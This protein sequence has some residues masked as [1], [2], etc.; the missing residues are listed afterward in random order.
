MDALFSFKHRAAL[1]EYSEY[2]K[3]ATAVVGVM[4]TKALTGCN[5]LAGLD[6]QDGGVPSEH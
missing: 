4:K 5:G 3:M 2:S 1:E 6:I